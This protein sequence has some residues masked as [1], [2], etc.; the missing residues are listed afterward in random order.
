[1][2]NVIRSPVWAIALINNHAGSKAAWLIICKFSAVQWMTLLPFRSLGK[3][4]LKFVDHYFLNFLNYCF[5]GNL[6]VIW[7][8]N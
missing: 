1:M 5:L 2:F 8:W 4:R 7:Y 3:R 6:P